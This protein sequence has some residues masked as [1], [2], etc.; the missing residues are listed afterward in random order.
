M[1]NETPLHTPGVNKTPRRKRSSFGRAGRKCQLGKSR[2]AITRWPTTMGQCG[3]WSR[4]MGNVEFSS[5]SGG[6]QVMQ[7]PPAKGMPTSGQR[8]QHGLEQLPYEF[9]STSL[10]HLKRGMTK[11][12]WIE[13]CSWMEG[14]DHGRDRCGQTQRLRE[15]AKRWPGAS[16]SSGRGTLSSGR[17]SRRS[18]SAPAE[19]SSLAKHLLRAARSGNPNR[20]SCGQRVGGRPSSGRAEPDIRALC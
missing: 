6:S 15:L 12:K 16:T 2:S 17:T 11:R 19:L 13:A 20:P 18:A 5:N 4:P 10:A 1:E 9:S 3:G 14:T 7:A 8:R